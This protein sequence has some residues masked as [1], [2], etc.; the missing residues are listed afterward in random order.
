MKGIFRS[1]LVAC[2]LLTAS[3]CALASPLNINTATASTMAKEL[4][5]IGKIKAQAI[6]DYRKRHGP[7]QKVD[8]LVKVPGIGNKTLES[9]RSSLVTGARPSPD[10]MKR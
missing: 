1:I 2:V 4:D 8:D 6:V 10:N 5:G 3:F 9:L 7:F